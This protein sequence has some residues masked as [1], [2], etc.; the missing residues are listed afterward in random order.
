M[1]H[2]MAGD[3]PGPGRQAWMAAGKRRARFMGPDDLE[4]MAAM[5]HFRGGPP[6][7]PGPMFG[8]PFGGGRGRKRRG[9]VRIALLLLIAQEPQNGYQLMQAIETRSGGRWRPSPGS[10]YPALAQLEDE[11]LIHA[12]ERDGTKLF[13]ITDAGREMLAER[14]ER[15]APW[16]FA[17]DPAFE[18]EAD[19]R[20]LVSQVAVAAIQVTHAGDRQQIDRASALLQET[21]RGLYRIL[22]EDA[23]AATHDDQDIEGG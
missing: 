13:E 23:D 1:S 21:R 16:E 19:M 5:R 7:G 10:V 22:A 18:A 6:F 14:G 8:R 17:G 12:T 3:W 20:A 2:S 11:G 4:R 9:D 15:A